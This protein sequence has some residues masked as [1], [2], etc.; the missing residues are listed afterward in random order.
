MYSQ[1][2]ITS[3]GIAQFHGDDLTTIKCNFGRKT[4]TNIHARKKN[5]TTKF[6]EPTDP[7]GFFL[8]KLVK[9]REKYIFSNLR[10]AL[11]I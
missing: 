9:A 4:K 5:E 7:G 10:S 8:S 11:R 3:P 2:P 6:S 1:E